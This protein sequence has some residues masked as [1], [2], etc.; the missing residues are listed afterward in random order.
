[1]R[2]PLAFPEALKVCHVPRVVLGYCFVLCNSDINYTCM[3]L[4][5]VCVLTT[6]QRHHSRC[7]CLVEIVRNTVRGQYLNTCTLDIGGVRWCCKFQTPGTTVALRNTKDRK[8]LQSN[9]T[10]VNRHNT[11][12]K[13]QALCQVVPGVHMWH[14]PLGHASGCSTCRM[15]NFPH[16]HGACRTRCRGTAPSAR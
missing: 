15:P 3:H 10:T 16:A 8:H 2:A 9:Q 5:I 1:M 13:H 11:H 4:S 7:R 6:R 14:H 12:T